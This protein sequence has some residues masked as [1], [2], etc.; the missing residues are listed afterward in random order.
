MGVI[1]VPKP[2]TEPY[3]NKLFC[4]YATDLQRDHGLP[5]A[6]AYKAGGDNNCPF[7]RKHIATRP[8]KAWEM[9][10]DDCKRKDE[11][12]K[13]MS[14]TFLVKNRFVIKCHR[15]S[16]GLACVLCARFKESDTVCREIDALV[17]H[18]WKEHTSDELERDDDIVEC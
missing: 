1:P 13:A 9:I 2:K 4:V 14:R 6:D 3:T 17:D 10:T 5:L 15:E 7:C 16:G 18:L 12:G 11:H 8:G